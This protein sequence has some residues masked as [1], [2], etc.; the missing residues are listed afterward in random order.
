RSLPPRSPGAQDVISNPFTL[1]GL[2]GT[3]EAFVQ[4][5]RTPVVR[6]QELRPEYGAA[7]AGH[8]PAWQSVVVVLHIQLVGQRQLP[9][10]GQATSPAGELPSLCE[11]RQ[12]HASQDREE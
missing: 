11:D 5:L 1:T 3:P 12:E 2:V 10:I 7:R 6:P 9:Q 4:E 8:H